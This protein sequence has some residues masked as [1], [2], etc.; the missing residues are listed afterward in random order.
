MDITLYTSTSDRTA[1]TKSMSNANTVTGLVRQDSRLGWKSITLLISGDFSTFAWNYLALTGGG[2]T[3]YYFIQNMTVQRNSLIEITA[4]EDVLMT[5]RAEIMNARGLVTR[6]GNLG[7]MYY[8]D[9]TL[10]TL[11]SKNT[12]VKIFPSGFNDNPTYI[13]VAAEGGEVQTTTT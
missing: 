6:S 10:K 4:E 3:R 11:A 5:F 2:R 12:T 7:N 9:G 8:D 1:L 13:L